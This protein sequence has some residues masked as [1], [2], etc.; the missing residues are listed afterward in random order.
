MWQHKGKHGFPANPPIPAIP[1]V[2]PIGAVCVAV[3]LGRGSFPASDVC[4]DVG[5]M[6]A[7]RAVPS[8]ADSSPAHVP[9]LPLPPAAGISVLNAGATPVNARLK[10]VRGNR[11]ACL[12]LIAVAGLQGPD[13]R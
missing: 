5:R 3:L 7:R 6:R 8:G 2:P 1:S 10:V 11:W 12:T 9:I 4:R 13:R